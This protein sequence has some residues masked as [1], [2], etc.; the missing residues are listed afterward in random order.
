[1]LD[2]V[3]VLSPGDFLAWESALM[4]RNTVAVVVIAHFVALVVFEF[5]F[6]AVITLL[7]SWG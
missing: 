7:I 1:M 5:E 6:L 4:L 2:Y 3:V